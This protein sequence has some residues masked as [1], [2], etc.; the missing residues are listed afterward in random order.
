MHQMI[1]TD[2]NVFECPV[3]GRAIRLLAEKPW[4]E[5]LV[6]GDVYAAHRWGTMVVSYE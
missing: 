4:L 1:C 5:V 3:C 6:V 2:T